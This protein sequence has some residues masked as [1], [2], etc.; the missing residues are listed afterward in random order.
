VSDSA[1]DLLQHLL[2]SIDI[3]LGKNGLDDFKNHP[4]FTSIDWE[5]LR[6]ATAPYVPVVNSPS[7]TSNFDVD[8]IEPSNKDVVPPVSHAAFTGHHLPFIGFT[9]S[10][11]NR[12][13]D[14]ATTTSI[15]SNP[16]VINTS[17]SDIC[18]ST[19][20]PINNQNS[21]YEEAINSLKLQHASLLEELKR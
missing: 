4:F 7:D 6:Q 21:E 2:C 3:R 5:N 19:N 10:A 13:S 20:S 14:G 9:H 1:K 11:N 15:V 12:Y 17:P 16:T 18:D 8:D